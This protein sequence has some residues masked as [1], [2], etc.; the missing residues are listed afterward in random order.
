[1]S[2]ELTRLT[3]GPDVDEVP[4]SGLLLE[5]RG[6]SD[7]L[8]AD[9][10]MARVKDALR[11]VA[12]ASN[13]AWPD[14]QDWREL[15]PSWLVDACAEEESPEE[16]ERWLIWWRALDEKERLEAAN[17]RKWSLADWL[18]WLQ[19]G[20]RQ[21]SWWDSSVAEDGSLRLVVE[22]AGWPSPIGALEWLVRAAG[23][24]RIYLEGPS[25][26]VAP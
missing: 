8:G 1:M 17:S 14:L 7:L 5:L 23:A 3:V 11:I 24:H 18:H 13:G 9:V 26:R 20:E 16:S 10:M 25:Y 22:V 2:D 19:P 4:R 21:W 12:T 15:L 6:A